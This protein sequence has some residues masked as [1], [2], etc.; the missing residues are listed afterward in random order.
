MFCVNLLRIFWI[1]NFIILQI[2]PL[3]KGTVSLFIHILGMYSST[4]M[5]S[6]LAKKNFFFVGKTSRSKY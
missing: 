1:E 6:E 3:A 4:V 2:I 5:A